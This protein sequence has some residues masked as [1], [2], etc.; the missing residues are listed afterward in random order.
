MEVPF[1]NVEVTRCCSDN[2][3]H[4]I[5][6]RWHASCRKRQISGSIDVER[7]TKEVVKKNKWDLGPGDGRTDGRRC[8]GQKKINRNFVFVLRQ[9]GGRHSCDGSDAL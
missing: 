4:P 1:V 7:R 6:P 8:V 9:S 3:C 5:Y 2:C